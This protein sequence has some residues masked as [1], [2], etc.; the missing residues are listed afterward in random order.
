MVEQP[1][2]LVLAARTTQ[3]VTVD[4]TALASSIQN[5]IEHSI[6][7]GGI[8][9]QELEPGHRI[10]TIDYD[11]YAAAAENY[12]THVILDKKYQKENGIKGLIGFDAI[13]HGKD[14]AVKFQFDMQ[15]ILNQSAPPHI[16]GRD[17][18]VPVPTT[19]QTALKL[20]VE[21]FQTGTQGV[22]IDGQKLLASL[23][24]IMA[25]GVQ[26]ANMSYEQKTQAK[27][28]AAAIISTIIGKIPG[29]QCIRDGDK[30]SLTIPI[31]SLFL[32]ADKY[33]PDNIKS[34]VAVKREDGRALIRIDYNHLVDLAADRLKVLLEK[35]DPTGRSTIT[36][37]DEETLHLTYS[38]GGL[39]DVINKAIDGAAQAALKKIRSSQPVGLENLGKLA[40]VPTKRIGEY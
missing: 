2:K 30:L 19:P 5:V 14:A 27:L 35:S 36:R 7:G 18:T 12:N 34:A 31:D 26:Y 3:E 32:M 15:A 28:Q 11:A 13:G 16:T 33:L 10:Y 9:K 6:N 20:L 38:K 1:K 40:D 4:R 22:M 25:P 37:I 8:E 23:Q 17:E 21:S 29:G 24:G 39:E